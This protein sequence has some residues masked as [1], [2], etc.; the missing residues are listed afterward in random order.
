MEVDETAS[1]ES[2]ALCRQSTTELEGALATAE[3][4]RDDLAAKVAER[5]AEKEDAEAAESDGEEKDAA[6]EPE[7][8]DT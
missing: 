4:E 3:A 7:D 6:E 1:S 5:K 8:A 2:P